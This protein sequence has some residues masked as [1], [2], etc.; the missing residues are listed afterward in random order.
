[1]QQERHNVEANGL[2]GWL[3]FLPNPPLHKRKSMGDKMLF[4][5]ALWHG[6]DKVVEGKRN[7]V[8]QAEVGIH[9]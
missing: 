2:R 8:Y 9:R 5:L 7:S 1:M 4:P 3:R 6:V